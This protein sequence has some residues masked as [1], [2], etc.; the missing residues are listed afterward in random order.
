MLDGY[1]ALSRIISDLDDFLRS[2]H[3]SFFGSQASHPHSPLKRYKVIHDNL[4]GTSRFTWRE[5]IIID[6]PVMQR[7]R[8]IHQTGLA[9]HVYPS[10]R[11]SR[12][13]HSLGVLTIASRVFD[14]LVQRYPS[15]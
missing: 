8:D 7:L 14:S 4:W 2:S 10:A 12:F 13:E 1:P 6:S 3:P 9:Y 11:H 15:R 5:M